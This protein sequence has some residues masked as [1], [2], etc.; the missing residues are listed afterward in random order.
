M[1]VS[2]EQYYSVDENLWGRSIEAGPLEDPWE[3][4][5]EEVWGW[6]RSAAAAPAEPRDV[7]VGFV[8][9]AAGVAGRGGAGCSFV[10]PADA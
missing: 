4:P 10:D 8:W 3:E 9:G 2:G 7:E 1:T 5:P 6:T